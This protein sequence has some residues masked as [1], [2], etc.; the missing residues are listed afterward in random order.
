MCWCFLFV[1][2]LLIAVIALQAE[3]CNGALPTCGADMLQPA[4]V[5]CHI[6]GG[7][8]DVN[9]NCTGASTKARDVIVVI[10]RAHMH[11]V[12]KCGAVDVEHCVSTVCWRVRCR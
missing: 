11:A 9:A 2:G 10:V 8:C 3:L 5:V 6:A 7:P 1:C 12:S 4:S